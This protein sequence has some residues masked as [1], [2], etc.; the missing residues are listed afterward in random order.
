MCKK[1]LIESRNIGLTTSRDPELDYKASA[2]ASESNINSH[3]IESN[4]ESLR[5]LE[6][7]PTRPFH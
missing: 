7:G 1:V 6:S 5:L 4:A 3:H 2:E